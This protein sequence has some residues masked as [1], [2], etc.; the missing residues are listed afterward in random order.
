VAVEEGKKG[1]RQVRYLYRKLSTM[2]CGL[3]F[4]DGDLAPPDVSF[5]IISP[6]KNFL[7]RLA[8]EI[9]TSQ[10]IDFR[11]RIMAAPYMPP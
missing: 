5:Q 1:R 2:T 4:F 10:P 8:V 11:C 3:S 9:R 7:R 6:S